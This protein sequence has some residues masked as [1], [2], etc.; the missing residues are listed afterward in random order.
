MSYSNDEGNTWAYRE[1][2]FPDIGSGQR[3]VLM[4]L[5]EG[6]L[7]LMSFDRGG[8]FAS[9][10]FDEGD[11]WSERKRIDQG[12]RGYLAATQTPDHLI[13]LITSQQYYRFNLA[14]LKSAPTAAKH[15]QH[16]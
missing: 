4:R 13:H 16:D 11:T 15:G 1:S 6:P 8:M 14:W 7:L 2:P 10:S 5:A 9:L 3:L 12:R